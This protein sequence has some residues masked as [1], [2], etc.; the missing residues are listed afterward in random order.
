M[1]DQWESY[2]REFQRMSPEQQAEVLSKLS[3][4]QRQALEAAR[5]YLSAVP[6]NGTR[7]PARS[8]KVLGCV[9]LVI[10]V[11]A[12]ASILLL[13]YS[14]SDDAGKASAP[15]TSDGERV[16]P[17]PAHNASDETPPSGSKG[18][19]KGTGQ[20]PPGRAPDYFPL[21]PGSE[22]RY[23][24]VTDSIAG[25]G[26]DVVTILKQRI[27]GGKQVIPRVVRSSYSYGS[28]IGFFASG[29]DGIS[30]F[31]AQEAE[32]TEPELAQQDGNYYLKYPLETGK[33]WAASDSVSSGAI[34][35]GEGMTAIAEH[36]IKFTVE[37]VIDGTEEVVT[38]P[39][40]TFEHCILVHE[41]G[42]A[43]GLAVDDRRWYAPN[44][45]LVKRVLK[46]PPGPSWSWQLLSFKEP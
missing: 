40:G 18:E 27:L 38:V 36:E 8:R 41:S 1:K 3:H 11:G 4:E 44:V 31:A 23:E 26:T 39:A 20:S 6:P 43:E 19:I 21:S 14:Q 42:D 10:L 34:V 5:T 9:A 12:L 46:H 33:T 30:L 32:A 2:A 45:G 28:S 29:A 16:N 17:A 25:N 24:I 7:R 15:A 35:P 22:W 13:K 37:A